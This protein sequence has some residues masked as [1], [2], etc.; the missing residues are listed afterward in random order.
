MK[1]LLTTGLAASFVFVFAG[2]AWA[3]NP[4]Q[5][6]QGGRGGGGTFVQP[7]KSGSTQKQ[8]QNQGG[9]GG[10]SQG[11]IGGGQVKKIGPVG[12]ITPLP[13][14]TGYLGGS[15]TGL[16]NSFNNPFNTFNNNLF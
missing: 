3:Q 6:F 7:G 10:S 4:A 11:T 15:F 8:N 16:N 14:L 12:Q 9:Q 5:S 13:M 2:S 1:R